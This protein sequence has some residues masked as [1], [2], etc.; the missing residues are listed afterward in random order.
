LILP[1]RDDERAEDGKQ[2]KKKLQVFSQVIDGSSK[3][4][5]VMT[6]VRD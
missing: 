3:N 6:T 4:K 5:L 1:Q 2:K